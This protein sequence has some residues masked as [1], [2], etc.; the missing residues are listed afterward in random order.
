MAKLPSYMKLVNG[1]PEKGYITW[2]IKIAWW[3]WPILA[4]K[5]LREKIK[6]KWYQ[7]PYMSIVMI[8]KVLLGKR[9]TTENYQCY[10]CGLLFSG[11]AVQTPGT[12]CPRC[13]GRIPPKRVEG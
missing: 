4:C 13:N 9:K 6:V 10:D 11:D 1:K 5:A 12:N 7:W 8:I 2:K 3:G